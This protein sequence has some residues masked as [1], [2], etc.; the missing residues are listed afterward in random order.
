MIKIQLFSLLIVLFVFTAC[1]NNQDPKTVSVK[2][3]AVKTIKAAFQKAQPMTMSIE[4]M[5]CAV[6]CAAMI[7]K[8]LNQ[9]AGIKKAKVDFETKKAT[10]IFDSEVLSINEVTQ[11]VLNT[12]EAY[13]VKDFKMLD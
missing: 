8:N 1:K 9:T 6:G 3:T 10:L 4:G 11:V 13:K 12:G 5:V 2:T 7:E